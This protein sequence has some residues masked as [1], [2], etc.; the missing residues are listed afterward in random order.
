[1]GRGHNTWAKF[2]RCLKGAHDR[3]W[4]FLY[5][6]GFKD[7][8][9]IPTAFMSHVVLGAWWEWYFVETGTFQLPLWIRA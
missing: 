9:S 6:L 1:M 7:F 5:D 2:H 4:S 8:F 3:Y